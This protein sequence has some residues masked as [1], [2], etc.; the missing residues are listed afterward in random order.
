[1]HSFALLRTVGFCD[2][3][4]LVGAHGIS[5]DSVTVTFPG[6]KRNVAIIAVLMAELHLVQGSPSIGAAF[7]NRLC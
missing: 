2:T 5:G 4:A 7:F 1:M 3:S 6:R